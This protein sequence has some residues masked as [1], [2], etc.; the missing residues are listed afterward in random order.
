MTYRQLLSLTIF[1]SLIAASSLAYAGGGS[2]KGKFVYGGDAPKAEA[3]KITADVAVCGK[4][5]LTDEGLVV[6]KDGGL[7]NVIL[8]LYLKR[9]DTVKV[10]P[11]YDALK[12]MPVTMINEKCRFEPHVTLLWTEQKLKVGNKDSVGHNT[13]VNCLTNDP[14]NPLLPANGELEIK[15]DKSERLP[16]QVGCNIHPWMTGWLVIRD[17]PYFAVTD[18]EGNFEIKNIPAGDWQFQ[19]WHE[20]VGYVSDVKI[21]GRDTEWSRGR[22]DVSVKEGGVVDLGSVTVPAKEFED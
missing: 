8:F 7:A 11:A 9:G 4:H 17:N 10:D 21:G 16:C 2:F 13:K 12:E 5:G 14:I 6:G 19:V 18:A 15:F 20:K 22:V 1:A 3:L